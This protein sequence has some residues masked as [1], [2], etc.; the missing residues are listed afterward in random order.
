MKFHYEERVTP[1]N[2][3]DISKDF[4]ANLD[5]KACMSWHS[6]GKIPPCLSVAKKLAYFVSKYLSVSSTTAEIWLYT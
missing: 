1:Y 5:L 2:Q 4:V 6:E 3:D